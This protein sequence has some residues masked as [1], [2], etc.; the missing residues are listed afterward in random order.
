MKVLK[1]LTLLSLAFS[2]LVFAKDNIDD[3]TTALNSYLSGLKRKQF[4]YDHGKNEAESSKLRDSW[5]APL[6]LNYSYSRSKPFT[7]ELTNQSAAIRMD[8]P[9]FKS[10]GI[11]YG[12]KFAN[13]SRLYS[14][15]TIEVAKRK[16]IKDTIAILMQLKQTDM[17]IA[18]QNLQIQNSEINLAQKKEQYLN[19]QLDSGFLNNAI[20][21]RN[22]VIQ[23]LY[24]IESNKEKLLNQFSALSDLDAKTAKIPHLELMNQEEFLAHNIAIKQK[25]AA[26]KKSQYKKDITVV[27]YLPKV[28]F[29]AGYSWNKS[30]QQF[31]TTALFTKDIKYYDYGIRINMP[32]DLNTFRDIESAKID[33]LKSQV[34]LKDK[35][36]E[37]KALFQQILKNIDNFN[38]KIALSNENIELYAKLSEDTKKLFL[39]GYKTQYDVDTL[40]NSLKIQKLNSK[41]YEIDKQ[42]ELL[43][44]Y[45]IY[46]NEGK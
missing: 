26:I 40:S 16:M 8:Q 14:N 22:N 7:K 10:G 19:G 44:L 1:L 37:F 4:E 43:K 20:I 6:Q 39:A 21:Q 23:A 46:V 12:I 28:N 9:I 33:F 25:D 42:L 30:Q 2:S 15:Y 24:D 18:V 35:Q 36:R 5:I 32:I 17:R 29:T 11:Y 27:K 38:K 13:A 41:I 3:N 31:S 45:E 34:A